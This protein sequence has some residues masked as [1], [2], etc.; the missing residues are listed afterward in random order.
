M[1]S[2]QPDINVQKLV[3]GLGYGNDASSI[4]VD[5]ADIELMKIID[6]AVQSP[7]VLVPVSVDDVTGEMVQ[8]DGCGDGRACGSVFAE[9]NGSIHTFKRSLHRPKAFGGGVTMTA[10]MLVGDNEATADSEEAVFTHAMQ[11]LREHDTDFGAHTDDQADSTHCGCGAIDKFPE[12]LA[13]SVTY[14][15]E[16]AGSIQALGI[17]TAGLQEIQDNFRL[18]AEKHANESYN[19][20]N[21]SDAIIHE[22]KVVKELSGSHIEKAIVLNTVPGYTVDQCFVRKATNGNAD[23][24]AVD[25]WHMYDLAD[26][27]LDTPEERHAGLLSQLVYTLATASVLTRGNLPVYVVTVR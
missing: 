6:S 12:I 2:I 4:S 26:K 23:V 7:A 27:L 25:V 18:Y 14:R 11:K 19:G 24:F 17:E 15:D 9:E 13:A 3:D 21:V 16:I 5:A 1:N 22:G 10:A 8:D 20:H